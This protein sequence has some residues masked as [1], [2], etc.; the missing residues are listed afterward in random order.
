MYFD[1]PLVGA[2]SITACEAPNVLCSTIP[3]ATTFAEKDRTRENRGSQPY[4]FFFV[5]IEF[6]LPFLDTNSPVLL[7]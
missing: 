2:V 1:R 3:G 6:I 7:K 4:N 5:E